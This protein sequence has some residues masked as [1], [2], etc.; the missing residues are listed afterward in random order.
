[1]KKLILVFLGM[2]GMHM[3]TYFC[4]R[5]SFFKNLLSP[6]ETACLP[7]TGCATMQPVMTSVVNEK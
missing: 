5:I 1:M 2:K 7:Y 3:Q 6:I 4:L